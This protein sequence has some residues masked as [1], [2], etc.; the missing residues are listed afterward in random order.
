MR[1]FPGSTELASGLIERTEMDPE[2]D[3]VQQHG[4]NAEAAQQIN[5]RNPARNP[6][7]RFLRSNYGQ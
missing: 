5:S 3:V 4:D 6:L 2:I 1:N 7:L